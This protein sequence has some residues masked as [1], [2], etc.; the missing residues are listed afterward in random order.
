MSIK[1]KTIFG[2]IIIVTICFWLFVLATYEIFWELNVDWVST[3]TNN[4]YSKTKDN[5]IV[6]IE[7]EAYKKIPKIQE[8][9]PKE[10][11]F[12][13]NYYVFGPLHVGG[14]APEG[15]VLHPNKIPDDVQFYVFYH[16][17]GFGMC[18]NEDCAPLEGQVVKCMN[19]WLAGDDQYETSF[20]VGLDHNLVKQGIASI[21]V[22]SDKNEKIIGIFPYH[23]ESDIIPILNT[24][25]E[26][27][28]PLERCYERYIEALLQ[29]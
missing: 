23:T 13:K 5:G 14:K 6:L 29:S 25:P 28:E 1:K 15:I 26:F 12:L 3:N 7:N 20:Q 18:N 19:G 17:M 2:T 27:Q 21:I 22:V 24:F 10:D 4:V 8:T 11:H 16:R 9:C